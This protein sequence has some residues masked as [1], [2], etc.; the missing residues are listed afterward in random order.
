MTGVTGL[1]HGRQRNAHICSTVRIAQPLVPIN[2]TASGK[3]YRQ[4]LTN[5]ASEFGPPETYLR[6]PVSVSG[7]PAGGVSREDSRPQWT[8]I[9]L[10]HAVAVA[11]VRLFIARLYGLRQVGLIA[12][13]CTFKLEYLVR[14][15]RV[16]RFPGVNGV[17]IIRSLGRLLPSADDANLRFVASHLEQ[18]I[19]PRR[20]ALGSIL[21]SGRKCAP[22]DDV[23]FLRFVQM[24]KQVVPLFVDISVE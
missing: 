11:S 7:F 4:S 17:C 22:A 21:G 1:A 23:D 13:H 8:T 10:A 14:P 2:A 15:L 12:Y 19:E 9:R 6:G 18:R 5:R 16:G 20:G 3:V 24:L